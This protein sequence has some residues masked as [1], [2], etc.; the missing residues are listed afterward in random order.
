MSDPRSPQ[1]WLYTETLVQVKFAEE[2]RG[3]PSGEHSEKLAAALTVEA[4]RA[5]L[6]RVDRV[7][8]NRMARWRARCRPMRCTTKAR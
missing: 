2:A 7:E 4:A 6:Y 5:G 1:N 3:L 8:L